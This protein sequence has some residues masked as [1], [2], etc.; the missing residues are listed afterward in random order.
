M[1]TGEQPIR[2]KELAMI[3]WEALVVFIVFF[4]LVTV[5]GFAAANWKAADLH[6]AA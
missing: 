2:V 3:N 1:V 6:Q 4:V 5:L